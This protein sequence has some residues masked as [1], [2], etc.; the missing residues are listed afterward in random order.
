MSTSSNADADSDTPLHIGRMSKESATEKSMDWERSLPVQST[1]CD[2]IT[3]NE[4]NFANKS[5]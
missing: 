2:E 5:K 1:V 3:Y 4:L